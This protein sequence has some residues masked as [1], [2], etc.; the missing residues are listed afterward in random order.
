MPT[1]LPAEAQKALA[2]YQVARTIPEKIKALEEALSLIPDHKGTEK[3]R[4]QLKRR[5]AELKREAERK[6]AAKTSRRDFFTVSKEGDSQVVIIGSTNSGKSSLL[7]ALTNAKPIV[8][9]YPFSTDK[10]TPGMMYYEDVEIQL[11]E[12]PAILT[13]ELEETQ[14][15]SRSLGLVK[16][17]DGVII[18]L[19]GLNNPVKQLEKILELLDEA[20]ISIKPKKGEIIIEKK[21]SG[22]IRIVTFGK[23]HGTYREVEELLRNVG[24]KNA[25]VKIY[26]DASIEDLE[27]TIIRETIYKKALIVLNKVDAVQST[28]L[29]KLKNMIENLQI[30]FTFI[31]AEKKENL[32]D[33]KEKIFKSLRLIRVYTQKDGVV[34]RKP[35]VMNE[36][37]TVRELAERIH[38]DLARKMKYAR[39]WG[40]SVKIQGQQVGSDH[41]LQDGDIIEIYAS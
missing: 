29:N 26:G 14:Y 25:V 22:G 3:L 28:E 8:A 21:D 39:I 17:S 37:A 4:G 18:L 5:I 2:K 13:E 30:P 7:R 9:P 20:G 16:N 1:N 19:D 34:S 23:F 33:L 38:K 24:I 31:S 12:L 10:P 40:R 6:A 15:T 41:I 11:V 27:E 36:N 35:I 32:E